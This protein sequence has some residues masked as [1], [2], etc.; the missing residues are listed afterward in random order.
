MLITWMMMA[1]RH[2]THCVLSHHHHDHH[3]VRRRHQPSA[4]PHRA[5]HSRVVHNVTVT[6]P[7]RDDQRKMKRSSERNGERAFQSCSSATDESCRQPG[8]LGILMVLDGTTGANL[9]PSRGRATRR[10]HSWGLWPAARS[11]KGEGWV[12][13]SHGRLAAAAVSR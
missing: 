5:I 10:G 1:H 6:K 11:H 7:S 9:T 4:F 2:A 13:S 3:L 8:T 12:T